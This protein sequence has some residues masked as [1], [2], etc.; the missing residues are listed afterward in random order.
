MTRPR[1]P[2]LT[3]RV[4]GLTAV[5]LVL[6]AAMVVLGLW[7]LGVY[8]DHQQDECPGQAG[9]ATGAV[10]RRAGTG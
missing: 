10:G 1:S 5:A 8:D 2:V 4:V 7:Q 6:V 9:P 3:S